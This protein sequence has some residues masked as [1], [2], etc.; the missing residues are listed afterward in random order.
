MTA[1]FLDDSK[2][3]RIFPD[4]CQFSGWF[5]KCPDFPDADGKGW[6]GGGAR[7]F[8]VHSLSMSW[9]AKARFLG[10]SRETVSRTSS[11]KFLHVES[12]Y[13]ESFGVLCLWD[14]ALLSQNDSNHACA[15]GQPPTQVISVTL[16]ISAVTR[17]VVGS[18]VRRDPGT[19][20]VPNFFENR[21]WL[22]SWVPGNQISFWKQHRLGWEI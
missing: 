9:K 12:C 4:N 5:Q 18:R 15:R 8:I 10:L 6:E 21:K 1:N 22:S 19:R 3:V 17:T 7:T 14:S 13:P 11:G 2:T 20:P 16:L